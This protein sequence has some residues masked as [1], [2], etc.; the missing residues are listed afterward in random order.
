MRV[1]FDDLLGITAGVTGNPAILAHAYRSFPSDR[2]EVCYA[3]IY[4]TATVVKIVLAQLLVAA[5]RGGS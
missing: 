1:P 5:G 2:V 4:P 3:M